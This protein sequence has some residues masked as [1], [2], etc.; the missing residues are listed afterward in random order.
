MIKQLAKCAEIQKLWYSSSSDNERDLVCIRQIQIYYP[1]Y[2]GDDH[3]A[4]RKLTDNHGNTERYM[5]QNC[6]GS[7]DSGLW[8][9]CERKATNN[10]LLLHALRIMHNKQQRSLI[11]V[12]WPEAFTDMPYS[13]CR[14]TF[15][16]RV[17]H[18]ASQK[19]GNQNVLGVFSSA[20]M[21]KTLRNITICQV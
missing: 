19:S 13:D 12:T 14:L 15:R 16:Q 21:Y 17:Q 5:T 3:Q 8:T 7:A 18:P 11:P 20:L 2:S 9:F 1:C 6:Q 10:F 4:R